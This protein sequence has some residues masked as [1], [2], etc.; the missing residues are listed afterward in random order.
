MICVVGLVLL[1][2]ASSTSGYIVM[3]EYFFTSFNAGAKVHDASYIL[4][5]MEEMIDQIGE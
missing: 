1:D 3:E 5:L 4:R 2:E